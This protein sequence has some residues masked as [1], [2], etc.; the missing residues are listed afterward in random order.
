MCVVIPIR[1]F[2][3]IIPIMYIC[4][5]QRSG[6][7]RNNFQGEHKSPEYFLK[8][9]IVLGIIEHLYFFHIFEE[10]FK[11]FKGLVP[12][13]PKFFAQLINARDD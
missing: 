6:A 5:Y 2:V 8:I 11:T 12:Q 7:I 4:D 9:Y 13:A 3:F 1:R 10:A